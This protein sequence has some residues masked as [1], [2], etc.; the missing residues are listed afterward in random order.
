M[1]YK[2]AEMTWILH[3]LLHRK[4]RNCH[5]RKRKYLLT[6]QVKTSGIWNF[7][8][9]YNW[10]IFNPLLLPEREKK[11]HWRE[12][13]RVADTK[14]DT[15]VCRKYLAPVSSPDYGFIENYHRQ[16]LFGKR[17]CEAPASHSS[18]FRSCTW[19]WHGA[20][21]CGDPEVNVKIRM[22]PELK[23]ISLKVMI[24]GQRGHGAR[25]VIQ[26]K[27]LAKWLMVKLC[28]LFPCSCSVNCSFKQDLA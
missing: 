23:V 18:Q 26:K 28:V 2:Q 14:W 19:H 6:G 7:K 21:V 17:H 25:Y 22:V 8:K 1:V 15:F 10:H 16:H 4:G 3:P 27:L 5:F 24:Q 12:R 9:G 20:A 13:K 11:R